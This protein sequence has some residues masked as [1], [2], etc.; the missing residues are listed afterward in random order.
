MPL[1]RDH[2]ENVACVRRCAEDI[3][4]LHHLHALCQQWARLPLLSSHVLC[5]DESR[6]YTEAMQRY[7][8]LM[9]EMTEFA[10]YLA[11]LQRA[12]LHQMQAHAR[13]MPKLGEC[14]E[15]SKREDEAG[16]V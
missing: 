14:H 2:A 3:S 13:K 10:G 5:E 15:P 8:R 7:H 9:K 4:T 11:Y 16:V 6:T 1:T 12:F